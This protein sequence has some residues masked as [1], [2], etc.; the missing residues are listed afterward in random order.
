MASKYATSPYF[1]RLDE[2]H[3]HIVAETT[4]T[5]SWYRRALTLMDKAEQLSGADTEAF[6]AWLAHT[7]ENWHAADKVIIHKLSQVP[8][9]ENT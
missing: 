3:G 6:R 2:K 9:L 4:L 5:G 7:P 8:S 1:A